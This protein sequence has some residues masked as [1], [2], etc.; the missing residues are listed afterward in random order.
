MWNP[1]EGTSKQTFL[2]V[3]VL[4]SSADSGQR[5]APTRSVC[6]CDCD[7]NSPLV[8]TLPELPAALVLS[9]A[10]C[11]S[12]HRFLLALSHHTLLV[13]QQ[14]PRG[15]DSAPFLL[16]L[17]Y[18]L[19]DLVHA[20]SEKSS[21]TPCVDDSSCIFTLA[22]PL[23]PQLHLPCHC[24]VISEQSVTLSLLH[25][26]LASFYV[27][28]WTTSHPEAPTHLGVILGTPRL[29]PPCSVSP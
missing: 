8:L 14:V 22:S 15:S 1:R 6:P 29:L 2:V 17:S 28:E 13:F 24:S 16:S 12:G 11:L 18:L 10:L 27:E 3:P 25:T 23:R 7:S 26:R 20:Q 9:A 19:E 4:C 5:S 21:F